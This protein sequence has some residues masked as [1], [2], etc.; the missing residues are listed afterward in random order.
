MYRPLL[1]GA[2]GLLLTL[3][4]AGHG[5]AAERGDVMRAARAHHQAL[6]ALADTP[7]G[8][9]RVEARL[10]EIIDAEALAAAVIGDGPATAEQ[11]RTLEGLLGRLAAAR[12]RRALMQQRGRTIARVDASDGPDGG[13]RI[14]ITTSP[15]AGRDPAMALEF[16][17]RDRGDRGMRVVDVYTDQVSLAEDYTSQL[18]RADLPRVIVNVRRA[19]GEPPPVAVPLP[20]P[21]AAA[22]AH[23]PSPR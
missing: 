22:P 11:R 4:A 10:A 16:V 14:K 5:R 15:V 13:H 19:L 3:V 12:Y 9:A 8:R 21:P 1:I 18:K 20:P 6:L 17:M 23:S 2:L 7:D